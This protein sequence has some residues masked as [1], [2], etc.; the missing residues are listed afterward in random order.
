MAGVLST[1]A[2]ALVQARPA[3]AA[4][5]PSDMGWIDAHTH[6][7]TANTA[8]Y[9]LAAGFR[10]DEM[11]PLSFTLDEFFAHARPTGVTRAV[12]I[13]MSFYGFDQSYLVNQIAASKGTCVGVAVID[14]EA[15]TPEAEMRRLAQAGVRGFRVYPRNHPVESWLDGDGMHAM[16]RC[17]QETSLSICPLINPN[18][19]PALDAMCEKYPDTKV[20]IDHVARIGVDG[21][22]RDAEIAQLCRLA[23]RPQTNVKVSAFYALGKK[24]PPYAD[25]APLI[26][27]LYDAYGPQRLMWASD[28]PFQVAEHS[29]ADSIG[30]VRDRLDFLSA[31]DQDWLLR[32]TAERVFFG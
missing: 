10:R 25:L 13:Q 32:K 17:A 19:L 20:V 30:L 8:R 26:R 7:W 4:E 1:A 28:C 14:D 23:R 18:A 5:S 11:R 6:V 31:S 21:A 9:P 2:M 29:Y 22:L 12:L 16:W 15:P 24:Q 27:R 3:N